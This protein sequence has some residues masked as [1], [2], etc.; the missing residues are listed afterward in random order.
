MHFRLQAYLMLKSFRRR[1]ISEKPVNMVCQARLKED[2]S[3]NN[4]YIYIALVEQS[5]V[6]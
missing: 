1:K 3:R 4:K 2:D 5:L 6:G